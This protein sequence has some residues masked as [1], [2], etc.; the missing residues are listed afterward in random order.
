MTSTS[1]LLLPCHATRRNAPLCKYFFDNN[2]INNLLFLLT[3]AA[4]IYHISKTELPTLTVSDVVSQSHG[5]TSKSHKE[6]KW[7]KLVIKLII[8]PKSNLYYFLCMLG[9]HI[10]FGVIILCIVGCRKFGLFVL[11]VAERINSDE[12]LSSQTLKRQPKFTM[13]NHTKR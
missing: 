4:Y 1:A 2:N 10:V 9:S 13:L 11:K 5:L 7:L 6:P 12:K 3:V 8:S